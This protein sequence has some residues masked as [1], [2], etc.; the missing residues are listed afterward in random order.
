MT[1]LQQNR[2][3]AA[4]AQHVDGAAESLMR[5][6]C[7]ASVGFSMVITPGRYQNPRLDRL[8]TRKLKEMPVIALISQ[9]QCLQVA[10]P[11]LVG[12]Q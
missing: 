11:G 6:G 3:V 10:R 2:D 1:K 7:M 4:L 12:V 5:E 8:A 9:A